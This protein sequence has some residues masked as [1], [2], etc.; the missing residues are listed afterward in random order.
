M[1][2]NEQDKLWSQLSEETKLEYIEKYKFHLAE[3]KREMKCKDGGYDLTVLRSNT[4]VDELINMFG[5]HNLNPLPPEPKTWEDVEKTYPKY[6][7]EIK[8]K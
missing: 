3:S 1:E 4:I 7:K 8:E 6:V 2:R 5:F